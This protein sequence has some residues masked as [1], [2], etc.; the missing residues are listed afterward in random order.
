MEACPLGRAK[1]PRA[2]IR[3]GFSVVIVGGLAAL[4]IPERQCLAQQPEQRPTIESAPSGPKRKPAEPIGGSGPAMPLEHGVAE[5]HVFSGIALKNDGKL[6]EAIAEFR[7][8]IRLKPDL[9]EAHNGLAEVFDAQGKR[10]EAVDELKKAIRIN[11]RLAEAHAD[12]GNAFVEQRKLDAAIVELNDAIRI[13]PGHHDAH[14]LLGRA[15]SRQGKPDEA[16][17][18]LKKAVSLEPESAEAHAELGTILWENGKLD[19]AIVQLRESVQLK[20]DFAG[21]HSNLGLA[22]RRRGRLDE[23]IDQFKAAIHLKPDLAEAHCMLGAALQEQNRFGEALEALE[24]GHALGS[25][26]KDWPIPSAELVKRARM[27]VALEGRIPAI[28]AGKDR[29]ANADETAT[30]ADLCY[31]KH[32]YGASARYWNEAFAAQP[33]LAE[34]F[35]ALNRYSAACSAALAGAGQGEDQGQLG[36]AAKARWRKKTLE[37][38]KADL[39]HWAKQAETNQPAARREVIQTL[40]HWK[41]DLDLAAV[42]DAAALEKLPAAEQKAFRALW[43]EVDG[44]LAKVCSGSGH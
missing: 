30:L 6:N 42:H 11:P 25:K 14:A 32:V 41:A 20:P 12:L 23:A 35:T 44:I 43:S 34:D 26:R 27:C 1:A 29:P 15:F 21:A 8:A 22:L 38:L 39:A 24:R 33:S 13:D 36:D 17:G 28:L 18:E 7:E 4:L 37:W 2:R 40:E 5:S 3:S 10:H 9:T 31:Q 16:I 19:E